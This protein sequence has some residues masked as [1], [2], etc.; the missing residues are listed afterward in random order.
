MQD[1]LGEESK[2]PDRLVGLDH[3]T[4]HFGGLG[5][6]AWDILLKTA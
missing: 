1:Q 5:A 4:V 6:V 2:E 3:W